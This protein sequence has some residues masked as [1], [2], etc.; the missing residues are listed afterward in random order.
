MP[1]LLDERQRRLLAASIAK[2]Y[3]YGGIK[4]LMD[5]NTVVNLISSTTTEKVLEVK[6]VV[7]TNTYQTGLK[8]DD[9]MMS[10]IDIETIGPNESWN[11]II[12]ELK[13]YILFRD[14]SLGDV[15]MI[16]HTG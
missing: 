3:G 5:I 12:R 8:A 13:Y 14:S 10:K 11:Y 15:G 2:G 6:C 1:K 7:D 9:G 4:P 16:G